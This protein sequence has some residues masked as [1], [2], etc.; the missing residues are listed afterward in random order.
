MEHGRP[1]LKHS[2]AE[3][4]FLQGNDNKNK[5]IFAARR[6]KWKICE[7]LFFSEC[8]SVEWSEIWTPAI[9]E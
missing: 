8:Q 1:L 4:Y 9:A 6:M 3:P 7:G 2:E 5:H